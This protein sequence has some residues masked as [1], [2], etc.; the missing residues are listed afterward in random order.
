MSKK[1]RFGVAGPA[2]FL[3]TPALA[4]TIK[5]ITKISVKKISLRRRRAR[6]RFGNPGAGVGTV[7]RIKA[8]LAA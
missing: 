1:S 6:C 3:G 5:D 4:G 7:L 8:E 2:A